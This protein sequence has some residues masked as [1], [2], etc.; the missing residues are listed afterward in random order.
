M[1]PHC[2]CVFCVATGIFDPNPNS[3]FTHSE[4]PRL[5]PLFV[6]IVKHNTNI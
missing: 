4:S 6:T 5:F 3:Q 1:S 2:S